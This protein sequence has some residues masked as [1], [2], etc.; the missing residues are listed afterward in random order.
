MTPKRL[1]GPCLAASLAL[2]SALGRAADPVPIKIAVFDFELDDE[3]AAGAAAKS[4]KAHD[5]SRMQA[6]SAEAR[7]FLTVSGRFTLIDTAGAGAEAV[8][9]HTLR[10]CGGCDASIARDLG[11]DQSL[12]GLV[13]RVANTE[14]YA[15]VQLTDARTG[16]ILRQRSAFFTGADDAWAAGVRM[17]LKHEIL[18]DDN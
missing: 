11:A 13:T 9:S 18:A 17:L 16:K 3:S 7:R 14:Y 10:A 1:I 12:L 4:D 2:A 15:S 5:E 6:V 8:K